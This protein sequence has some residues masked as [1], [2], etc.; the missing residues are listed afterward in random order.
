MVIATVLVQ[1]DLTEHIS[2]TVKLTHEN[3]SEKSLH[4]KN[5]THTFLAICIIRTIDNFFH[6]VPGILDVPELLV[7]HNVIIRVVDGY[8]ITI[9]RIEIIR[10]AAGIIIDLNKIA[11]GNIFFIDIRFRHLSNLYTSIVYIHMVSK[12][13]GAMIIA[14]NDKVN[15]LAPGCPLHLATLRHSPRHRI[16]HQRLVAVTVNQDPLLGLN[17]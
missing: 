15:H 16:T 12:G 9:R 5:G 17:G 6:I 13:I 14:V 2:I 3:V 10:F 8:G 1:E 11:T 7:L 4:V